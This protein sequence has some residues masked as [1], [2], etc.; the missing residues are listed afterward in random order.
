MFSNVA[1]PCLVGP[2]KKAGTPSNWQF[3]ILRYFWMAIAVIK[4][5]SG[6]K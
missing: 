6:I 4:F 3:V 1:G 5:T 2:Y